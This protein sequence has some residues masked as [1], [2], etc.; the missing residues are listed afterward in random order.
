MAARADTPVVFLVRASLRDGLGHLVRSLCVLRALATRVPVHL[1]VLG[2]SSGTHLIDEARS[3]YLYDRMPADKHQISGGSAA[4]TAAGVASLLARGGRGD[5]RSRGLRYWRS[6]YRFRWRSFRPTPRPRGC[7][8][9]GSAGSL[10]WFALSP[11]RPRFRGWR[12]WTRTLRCRK[13]NVKELRRSCEP[14]P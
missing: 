13:W 2:D 5:G 10:P 3:I 6:R 12:S 14:S 9:A 8:P 1:F 7:R 4:N 11:T